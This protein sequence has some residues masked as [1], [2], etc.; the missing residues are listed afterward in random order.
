MPINHKML[1]RILLLIVLWVVVLGS[2]QNL[3]AFEQ[4]DV[5]LDDATIKRISDS[6]YRAFVDSMPFIGKDKSLYQQIEKSYQ[7]EDQTLSFYLILGL[8]GLLG[9]LR[10]M[11][12]TYFQLLYQSFMSPMVNKRALREQ[13]QQ[14]VLAN[15][16]MNLF[17]FVSFGVFLYAVFSYRTN[18]ISSGQIAPEWL[19]VGTCTAT[20]LIYAVKYCVLRFV[21]WAFK[22]EQATNDYL[23]NV[24]LI[25][26]IL[27][28]VLLPFAI[29]LAFG[30]GAWLNVI[31]LVAIL[32]VAILLINRYTRSWS[33]LASFF[34]YSKFHFFMYFCA[35]E[36]LPLAILTKFLYNYFL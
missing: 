20:A 25:N 10:L 28:V 35:S 31:F 29:I 19:I 8:L 36:L 15:L 12:P 22:V 5:T 30:Q 1:H 17:F 34:Q 2:A 27:A 18:W 7:P 23:Y 6:T 14:N 16:A 21:G 11:F 26:K 13:I 3:F 32:L 33:S 4:Y 24:F 9:M